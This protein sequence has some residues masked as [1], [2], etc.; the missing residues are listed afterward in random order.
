MYMTLDQKVSL[1]YL[2]FARNQRKCVMN[3]KS[4]FLIKKSCFGCGTHQKGPI[5]VLLGQVDFSM[6]RDGLQLQVASQTLEKLGN[7]RGKC[8]PHE[9]WV[10]QFYYIKFF[11]RVISYIY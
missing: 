10:L 2:S 6:S 5:L 4:Q 7:F 11:N 8:R 1:K 3:L 9:K